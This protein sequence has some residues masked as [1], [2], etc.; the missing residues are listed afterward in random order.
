MENIERWA[1]FKDTDYLVSDYG[2]VISLKNN[3]SRILKA[4]IDKDGYFRVDLCLENKPK[5]FHVHRL[6]AICFLGNSSSLPQVNH[7]DCNKR[8]NHYKN[9]E[10]CTV[11]HNT[12]HAVE[13]GMFPDNSGSNNGQAKL[14]AS[15]VKE[16]RASNESPYSMGPKFNVSPATIY[17]IRK[18]RS[19]AHI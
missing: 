5:H 15:D 12:I 10:W 17:D 8:N 11:K 1:R 14:T 9:L 16:I 19:W 7:K 2:R 4:G 6:V 3:K 13:N 18:R